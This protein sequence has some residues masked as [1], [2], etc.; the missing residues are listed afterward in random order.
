ML[1]YFTAAFGSVRASCTGPIPSLS[2]P[3][4][5]RRPASAIANEKRWGYVLAIVLAGLYVLL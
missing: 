3:W 2:W 5:W 4:P 1:S